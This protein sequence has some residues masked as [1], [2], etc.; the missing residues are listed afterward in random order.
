M[1]ALPPAVRATT[2]G[3]SQI[4]TPELQPAGQVSL[5]FQAQS[6]AIG[7]PYELQMELGVTRWLEVAVFQGISPNEQIFGTILDLL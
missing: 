3:L 1:A 4:V 6:K 5:S 7:N 2:K